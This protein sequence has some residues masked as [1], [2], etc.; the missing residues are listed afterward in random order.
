MKNTDPKTVA[1]FGDEWSR[2]DQVDLN[3]HELREV[4]ENYFRIFPWN[5]LPPTA[6]GADIGCGS[7]RWA[8]LAAPRVG[9]LHCVDASNEALNVSRKALAGLS[10][11]DFK[12]ASAGALPFRDADLDFAYSLGVLH[13]VPDTQAALAECARVLKPG[14]PFLV[15]L[16]YRFDNRP[17]WFRAVWRVS[18]ALRRAVA[19]LPPSARTL[20]TDPVAATVY[21][22]L[23]RAARLAEWLGVP[24]DNIPLSAYRRSSFY[25]M[26]TD[27]LDRFGTNLEKRFTQ[28][29]IRQMLE[30]AGFERIEFSSASPFWC[31]VGRRRGP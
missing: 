22:P 4:F 23:A 21:F 17:P 18:D 2:F 30:H 26:R 16:Y 14:A 12:V 6:T 13:H 27:A 5:D 24:V 3:E 11:V 1:G 15:Y 25:T 9:R 19:Q 10:N 8:R 31:A 7:G 28:S 20:V 29:E